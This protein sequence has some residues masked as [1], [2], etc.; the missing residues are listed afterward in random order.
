MATKRQ[1]QA[2]REN[3]AKS[4]GPTSREGKAASSKNAMKHG[5]RA[6][7]FV[8]LDEEKEAHQALM[9]ALFD[10]FLP[11]GAIEEHL[12]G[13]LVNR[14]WQQR[15]IP[16]IEASLVAGAG[17][18]V[19]ARIEQYRK[20][21]AERA[22][23]RAEPDRS[24]I[25]AISAGRAFEQLASDGKIP[26]LQLLARY[27]AAAD[28]GLFRDLHELER[29]QAKRKQTS[30][31]RKDPMASTAPTDAVST[32]F[33][34]PPAMPT[35]S[36]DSVPSTMPTAPNDAVPSNQLSPDMRQIV[37]KIEKSG[38]TLPPDFGKAGFGDP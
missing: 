25:P 6:E 5:L 32:V 2:N 14:I 34:M 3:S 36:T 1:R 21:V 33:T 24:P 9:D 19:R 17:A 26:L 38:R 31:S 15:R 30:V 35:A 16:R 11:V 23:P 7:H 20:D 18:F 37:E 10:E 4:T 28:R 29:L 12:V 22:S 13:Q 8:Y 27:A